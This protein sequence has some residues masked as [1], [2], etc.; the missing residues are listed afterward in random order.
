MGLVVTLG[1]I[2]AASL[3]TPPLPEYR[4]PMSG[5]TFALAGTFGELRS[6]HFHSGIDI[7]T[8]GGIGQPLFAVREGYI[9]RIKVS[10]YGFGKAI[11]L[12]HADGEFS[13]YGHMN[14]F[15][16]AIEEFVFQKQYATKQYEQEIY[17]DEGQMPVRT[18]ELIG[19]S[20][21][22]GYSAGPHLH[23]EIRDPDERIMNPLAYYRLFVADHKKPL[24]SA[25]AFEPMGIGS[26]V[27]GRHEKVEMKPTGG[28][29][30]Y[31]V[32]E[33]VRLQGPVGLEYD[34]YDQ[35]DAAANS[36]GINYARLY[37]DDRL[38]YEF[39]LD[40]FSF[41]DKRYI[42]VHFDYQ[43]F[44]ETGRKLQRSYI[45]PGNRLTCY[46]QPQLTGV[47]DL[48]DDQVHALRLELAD[49]YRNTSTLR[50]NVQRSAPAPLPASISGG[51]GQS[52]RSSIHRNVCVLRLAKPVTRQ[53]GG[54]EVAY[55][56]GHS[57]KLLPAYLQ[58]DE[59]VYLLNL[60][61][62]NP[63]IFVHDPIAGHKVDF[64]VRQVVAP[65]RDNLVTEGELQVF[66]PTGCVFDSLPLHIKRRPGG[67]QTFSDQ[68][69]IGRH[70]QPL[71][72]SFVMSFAPTKAGERSHMVVA[73]K[74]GGSWVYVGKEPQEDGRIVASSADFGTFCVMADSIAP[75]IKPSNFQEGA[76]IGP[77]QKTIS[78][79]LTDEFSGINSQK[80]HCTI[81]G[82]WELFEYD[83]KGASITHTLRARPGGRSHVLQVMAWDN[84]G[85]LAQATW[86]I[87]Y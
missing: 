29:G 8:S 66:L 78:L 86:N 44:K 57:T 2:L 10:P 53:L 27:N 22:S 11:Y 73:R 55:L 46:P 67:S 87:V 47:I 1:L 82:N 20:G 17:L 30:S 77:N 40:K 70:D 85:N 18:G 68:Y 43:H 32:T 80:I 64:H 81:D 42:N 36:C 45:E 9:Y 84:A 23:F 62:P 26:R 24:V 16:P 63:P 74:Q 38:I 51:L 59:L 52:M 34:G 12:R 75:K 35:L 21:N 33:V 28:D 49:G 39:S 13:V 50:V 3:S 83:A 5:S 15:T 71:F 58:G 7:K 56:D 4:F 48:Q 72:R 37:M 41:D 79:S 31:H 60:N 14:G 69:E 6:N 65:N 76:T 25:I 61:Q 54:L 19:Y